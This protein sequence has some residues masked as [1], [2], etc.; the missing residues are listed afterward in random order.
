MLISACLTIMFAA[1]AQKS[2]KKDSQYTAPITPNVRVCS[3][4]NAHN[5]IITKN[6]FA[7]HTNVQFDNGSVLMANGTLI[8]KD[9]NRRMLKYGECLDQQGNFVSKTENSPEVSSR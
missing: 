6:G 8:D 5:T 2:D 3:W 9:G 1:E 4:S 7:L